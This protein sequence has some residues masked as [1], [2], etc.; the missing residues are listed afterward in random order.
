MK[1][2]GVDKA[3]R[4]VFVSFFSFVP[5]L[6]SIRADQASPT[7]AQGSNSGLPALIHFLNV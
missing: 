5:R 6:L 2:N 1:D 7:R 3:E 4:G